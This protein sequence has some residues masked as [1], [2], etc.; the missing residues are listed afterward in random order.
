MNKLLDF[1]QGASNGAASNVSAPV[2]GLAWLL[3]KAG[4]NVGDAPMGGSNWM[5][6]MGLTADPQN[7]LTGILGESFGGVA[8]M[9]AAAKAPQIANAI[10][11]GGENLRAP[12][13]MNPQA[14]AIVWHGPNEK[15]NLSAPNLKNLISS[16]RY[17]DRDIV[18]K[19]IREGNFDV[20]VTPEFEID[21]EMVRAIQDGHHALEAAIRSGNK[22][23][24]T[25]NTAA[26]SDRVQLLK[27]GNVDEY[28]DAAYHDA[29]WYNFATKRDLF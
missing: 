8:P 12:A 29:P 19:K 27:D 16:Q 13:T 25:E 14:G 11:K 17:L 9:L 6:A 2:D 26:Q 22:P 15:N 7:K 1:L 28:L 18:A 5:R 10:I 21:G 23:R 20:S 3:R 24:F 4:V